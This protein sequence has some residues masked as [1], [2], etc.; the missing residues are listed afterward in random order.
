MECTKLKCVLVYWRFW[1]F[2]RSL[3]VFASLTEKDISFKAFLK[4]VEYAMTIPG[5]F[6]MNLMWRWNKKSYIIFS[7]LNQYFSIGTNAVCERLFSQITNY[8]TDEKSQ[9][10]IDTLKCWIAVKHNCKMSCSDFHSFILKN[11]EL[12]KQIQSSDKYW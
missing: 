11:P 10:T 9:L 5:E 2:K 8:W 1:R 3:D 12:L 4:L 7:F 6:V